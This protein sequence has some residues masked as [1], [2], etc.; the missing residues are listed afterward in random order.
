MRRINVRVPLLLAFGLI[1]GILSARYIVRADWWLF[2]LFLSE[3]AVFLIW[4]LLK[5]YSVKSILI[6]AAAFVVGVCFTLLVCL[7]PYQNEIIDERCA[8]TGRVTDYGRNG[9]PSN[10]L[11]LDDCTINGHKAYGKIRFVSYDGTQFQTGDRLSFTATVNTV[12]LVRGNYVDARSQ[13]SG[14]KYRATDASGIVVSAGKT[15]ADE[16]VR[17]YVFDRAQK[18]MPNN[19]NVVYALLCGDRTP[20]DENTTES[21]RQ[22]GILHLLAVSGL[23]VGVL[24]AVIMFVVKRFRLN[25]AIELVIVLVPL[26]LYAWICGFTSSVVRAVVML[27]CVYVAKVLYGKADLLSSLGF[28]ATFILLLKPLQLFDAGFCLSFLSVFGIACLMPVVGRFVRRKK[29]GKVASIAI[30]SLCTSV[31]CTVATAFELANIGGAVPILGAIVNLVA[32]PLVW[33]VFVLGLGGMLPWIFGYLLTA[34]DWLLTALGKIADFV[35]SIPFSSVNFAAGGLAV[36]LCA[37]LLFVLGGYVHFSKKGKAIAVGVLSALLVLDCVFAYV[38]Q[39]TANEAYVYCA[40]NDTAVLV[41]DSDGNAT[42][43]CNF[44]DEYALGYAEEK[45]QKTDISHCQLVFSDFSKCNFNLL[46]GFCD[47][48]DVDK[49]YITNHATN[50][51]VEKLFA[52]QKIPLVNLIANERV[53]FGQMSI[54]ALYDGGLAAMV[55]DVDGLTLCLSLRN[56]KAAVG[57]WTNRTDID[58]F[59]SNSAVSKFCATGKPVLSQSQTSERLNYGANK[60]GNFTISRKYDKIIVSFV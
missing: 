25:P 57:Y 19:A 12:Y 49:A 45:L 6:V 24:A 9:E 44:S 42:L 33:I 50:A 55:I 38:P 34:S 28:A 56:E 41:T 32:V 36:A 20:L 7:A 21:Y 31:A 23:H 40:Y 39:K 46:Q 5:K 4:F 58:V 2:A 22:A 17:K 43:V 52:E 60:Y 29:L 47:K 48:I 1:F 51:K 54:Q 11:I 26:V 10:V 53:P 16:A 3:V 15:N 37:A 27:V 14:E 59:V 8:V 18:Y 35:S 13:R 30:T